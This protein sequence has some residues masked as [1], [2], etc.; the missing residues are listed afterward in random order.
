MQAGGKLTT[1]H[2]QQIET[3]SLLCFCRQR[4]THSSVTAEVESAITQPVL[5]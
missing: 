4:S 3:A 1:A 5:V 2:V